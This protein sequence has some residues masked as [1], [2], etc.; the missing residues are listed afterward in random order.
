MRLDQ[1]AKRPGAAPAR[2]VTSDAA[3][4]LRDGRPDPLAELAR[5]IAHDETFTA[6]VSNDKRSGRRVEH[7]VRRDE[8]PASGRAREDIPS[9]QDWDGEE[10]SQLVA[11]RITEPSNEPHDPYEYG[12][13]DE[14]D[15]SDGLP[16]RRRWLRMSAAVVGLALLGSASAFAYWAWFD[17]PASIEEAR[18]IGSS[19]APEKLQSNGGAGG[20][21]VSGEEKTADAQAAV[22]QALPPVVVPSGPA[23]AQVAALT[24]ATAPTDSAAAAESQLSPSNETAPAPTPVTATEPTAGNK[25]IVQLSSQRS[26]AAAQATSRGLQTKYADLFGGLAPFIRRSDLRDKGVYYRVLIGPFAAFGEANQLCG[27]LKKS[28]GD[29]VVQKN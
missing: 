21:T 1:M 20:G 9:D 28:G 24:P 13:G 27:S 5:L 22:P 15:Y 26:E 3:P 10:D 23:P 4:R 29:C 19:T 6:I 12:D 2:S 7:R 18:A 14:P 17:R 25:Y 11:S 8:R 16:D